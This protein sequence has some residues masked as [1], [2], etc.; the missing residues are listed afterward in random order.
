MPDEIDTSPSAH[1]RR[2]PQQGVRRSDPIERFSPAQ[3]RIV[4]DSTAMAEE[5]VSNRYKMSASQWL[6]PRYDIRTAADLT[7]TEIVDG[8]LAQIIRYSGQLGASPLG[9]AA[10]DFYK[11]CLQDH[12]ILPALRRFPRPALLPFVLYIMV[13][14]LVHI[15]RFGQFLQCF[16]ASAAEADAEERRVHHKTGEILAGLRLEG[17]PAVLRFYANRQQPMERL[18]VGT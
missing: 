6:R 16:E 11:I 5:L 3:I 10:F 13:H 18:R 9:S 1:Q 14:E 17:L 4:S 2:R 7:A 8:P 15:V 12:A